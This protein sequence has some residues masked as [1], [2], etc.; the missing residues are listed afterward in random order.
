MKN[1]LH[2][3]PV[4]GLFPRSQRRVLATIAILVLFLLN[5][6]WN[7]PYSPLPSH[8][9]WAVAAHTLVPTRSNLVNTPSQEEILSN[10][11]ETNGIAILGSILVLVIVG[12]TLFVL[13]RKT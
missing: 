13:R 3:S 1:N 4:N 5:A 8:A 9:P 7:I 6:A 2:H 10:H 11:S 12:G